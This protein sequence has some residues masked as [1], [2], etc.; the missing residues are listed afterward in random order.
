MFPKN[1]SFLT[2]E[3]NSETR[4]LEIFSGFKKKSSKLICI[5]FY[6]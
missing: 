5:R 4:I 1:K 6:S 3:L 2:V